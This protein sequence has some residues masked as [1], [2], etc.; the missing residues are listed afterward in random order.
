MELIV[1][2]EAE[3]DLTEASDWYGERESGL[4][5]KFVV[6]VEALLER[7]QKHPTQFPHCGKFMRS[8]SVRGFPYTVFYR[9]AE[10]K[11]IV[12]A[13]FHHR[14]DLSTLYGRLN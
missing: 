7:I 3:Q 14:R 9:L 11:I 8:A 6:K 13:V 2:P 5:A 12:V 1:R 4:R 10:G